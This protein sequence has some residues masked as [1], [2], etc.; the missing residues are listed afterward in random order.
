MK[1]TGC[2]YKMR[3]CITIVLL[4]LSTLFY[5]LMAQQGKEISHYLLPELTKGVVLMKNGTRNSALLNYNA[6]TEE[7]VFDQDGQILT[8]TAATLSQLDTVFIEHRKFILHEG[9]MVEVINEDGFVLLAHYRCKVIP[10]GKPAGYG[11]TSQTS[12]VDSYSSWSTDGLVYELE[13]PDDFKIRPYTEYW[14][15]SGSGWKGIKSLRQVRGLFKN[16]SL[17]NSYMKEHKVDFNDPESV[18]KLIQHSEVHQ[19]TP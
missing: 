18:A 10:P 8:F 4:S 7:M 6:A 14:L 16:R 17:Y 15:N 9:T 12:A 2:T 13:L 11:G 19:P 5:S 1:G 3:G